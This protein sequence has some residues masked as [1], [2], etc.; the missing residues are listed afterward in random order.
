M[1]H[2]QVKAEDYPLRILEGRLQKRE[3]TCCMIESVKTYA[4]GVAASRPERLLTSE[5]QSGTGSY[6]SFVFAKESTD[7]CSTENQ[8]CSSSFNCCRA[9][10]VNKPLTASIRAPETGSGTVDR[11]ERIGG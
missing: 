3:I 2:H 10:Q 8:L 6:T 11:R 1:Q 9:S 7:C 4:M 5:L